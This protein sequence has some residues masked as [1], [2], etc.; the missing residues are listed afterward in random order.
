VLYAPLSER[1]RQLY[2][3]VL[4]GG[5]REFL[6]GKT[7][8]SEGSEAG[9]A[10]DEEEEEEDRPMKLRSQRRG[11]GRKHYG[12]HDDDDEEY[13]NKLESGELDPRGNKENEKDI[14]E[15]GRAYQHK[16]TRKFFFVLQKHRTVLTDRYA[17]FQESRLIT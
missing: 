14:E 9:K 2:D 17:I 8:V 3:H 5:L 7:E 1:Q 10:K 13:F 16:A 11:K 15:I 4:A 6:M 12:E